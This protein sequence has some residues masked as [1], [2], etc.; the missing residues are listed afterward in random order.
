MLG[1]VFLAGAGCNNAWGDKDVVTKTDVRVVKVPDTRVIEKEVVKRVEVPLPKEC[2]DALAALDQIRS[3]DDEIYDSTQ[4]N[5]QD[6]QTAHGL[7]VAGDARSLVAVTEKLMADR[8]R[9]SNAAIGKAETLL[10]FDTQ[11]DQCKGELDDR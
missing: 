4:R 7:I 3:Y 6:V 8:Q 10:R 2:L 5:L 1:L 11:I 9:A